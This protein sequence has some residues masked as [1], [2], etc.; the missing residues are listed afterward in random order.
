MTSTRNRN[1]PGDYQLYKKETLLPC[2]KTLY[3]HSPYG[4]T[5][6]TYFPGTGLIGARIPRSELSSNSCD[7]ETQLFGIGSCDL[8]NPRP[9]IEPAIK[10]LASLNIC[11]KTPLIMPRPIS[12]NI[13]DQKPL[14]LN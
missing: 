11:E 13:Q 12:V 6:Q 2:D 3:I 10:Q 1:T 14:W 8:E 4:I 7:I 5:Q 9:K